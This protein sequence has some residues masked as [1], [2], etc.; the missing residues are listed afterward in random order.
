MAQLNCSI[1]QNVSLSVKALKVNEGVEVWL[2]SLNWKE[3]TAL[4]RLFQLKAP[5]RYL[6]TYSRR[7]AFKLFKCTFPVSKQF[8]STFILCFFKYL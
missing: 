3:V 7:G 1:A 6:L 5:K 8:K 2:F 4:P